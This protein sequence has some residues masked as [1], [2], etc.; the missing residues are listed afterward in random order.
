MA[1]TIDDKLR[2][3]CQNALETL[4]K[5]NIAKTSELQAKLEWCI[6][7]Y[8]FDKNPAGLAE[9]GGQAL[10]ELKKIKDKDPKK[11]TKKLIDGLE[12]AIAKFEAK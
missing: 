7:S 11:V 9:F 8:D 12:G 6:G 5:L 4:K 1:I 3:E 2:N 10:K